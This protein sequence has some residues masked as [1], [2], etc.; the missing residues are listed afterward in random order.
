MAAA[1]AAPNHVGF[2]AGVGFVFVRP[3][4]APRHPFVEEDEEEAGAEVSRGGRNAGQSLLKERAAEVE[5]VEIATRADALLGAVRTKLCWGK[6]AVDARAISAL[7]P[8]VPPLLSPST[9]P[10][11]PPSAA[12]IAASMRCACRT[13]SEMRTRVAA[14]DKSAAVALAANCERR[15][16]AAE[17]MR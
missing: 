7:T 16:I 10:P 4:P 14:A 11:E 15:P 17:G 9:A 2:L 8:V 1:T 6:A 12:S 13:S 5:V 3:L